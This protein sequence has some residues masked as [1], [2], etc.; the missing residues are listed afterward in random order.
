[1]EIL[2][3][4]KKWKNPALI[5]SD[6]VW[7]FVLSLDGDSDGSYVPVDGSNTEECLISYIDASDDNCFTDHTV[8]S[9][10]EYVWEDAVNSAVTLCDIGLTGMDNGIILFDKEAI[11]DYEFYELLTN[12]ALP[13]P[14][15]DTRL[16]LRP[17]SGNTQMYSYDMC[18]VDDEYLSFKGGFLQGFFKV[19]GQDYQVLPTEVIDEITFEFTL[20]PQDYLIKTN[21]L[22]AFYPENRGIFFYIGTR[23]ENKFAKMHGAD[24]SEYPDREYSG[25][26]SCEDYFADDYFVLD[27]DCCQ[28]LFENNR[29]NEWVINN[30]SAQTAC[31]EYFADDYYDNEGN[32]CQNTFD[33]GVDSGDSFNLTG[34][35]IVD[36]DGQMVGSAITET[37]R[38]DN[39]FLFFNRTVS[40]FT[41]QTWHEGDIVEYVI[42]S[43]RP[44]VNLFLYMN[45]TKNGLTVDQIDK[46][47]SGEMVYDFETDSVVPAVSANTQTVTYDVK[48]DIYNN[49]FALKINEDMSIGY[50]YLVKD[51]DVEEGYRIDEESTFPDMVKIGEWSTIQVKIKSLDG[52]VDKCG[53]KYGKDK[54]KVF[55]YVNGYLKFVSKELDDFS[56]KALNDTNTRQ[57]GVPYNISLGGGTQGLAESIW[58]KYKEMFPKVLPIEENFAG[59][60]IGDI[61]TFK[62][63]NCRLQYNQLKN[64]FIFESKKY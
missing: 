29:F 22:N 19:E 27:E 54:I 31:K 11:T 37:I 17:V 36:S 63:Y 64:N 24:L 10:S 47:W 14:N 48:K 13:L 59:S 20:R 58:L 15:G 3:K 60:F 12:T 46:V 39:K 26:T 33:Y 30:E 9:K 55:I 61:K 21:T 35:T 42:P 1:M 41:T 25:Q 28:N 51:C 40:G 52:L 16:T 50:K 6:N 32:C 44:N 4:Y 5:L 43:N 56:F 2:N 62:I 34:Q 18:R 7:D 53:N 23:A 38:T 49:A 57:Q 8:V 45:R